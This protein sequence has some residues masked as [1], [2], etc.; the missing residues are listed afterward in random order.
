MLLSDVQ[1]DKKVLIKEIN[2]DAILKKRLRA[3]GITKNI[4]ATVLEES[5]GKQNIKISIGSAEVALR[6]SEAKQIEVE[7]I[8]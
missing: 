7:E 2:A 8:K 1:T 6:A 5:L 3:L 4:K